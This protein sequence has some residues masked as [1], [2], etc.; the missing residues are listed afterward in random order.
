MKQPILIGPSNFPKEQVFLMGPRNHPQQAIDSAWTIS[1]QSRFGNWQQ[2]NKD[3]DL[4]YKIIEILIHL[5][6]EPYTSC[7]T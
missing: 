3:V 4:Y 5:S 2:P 7:A 6:S 1:N